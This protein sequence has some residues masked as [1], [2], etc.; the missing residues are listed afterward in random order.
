MSFLNIA[1]RGA[2]GHEPENTLAA[3]EKAVTLGADMIEWD[4]HRCKSG[5]PV[6]IHDSTLKRTTNGRG[7]I[8][9]KTLA[10]LK[11]LDAGRGQTIPTLREALDCIRRRTMVNIELKG[12]DTAKPV[13][14]VIDEY[15]RQHRWYYAD[16]LISSFSADTLHAFKTLQPNVHIGLLTN[17]AQKQ[18]PHLADELDIYSIHPNYRRML[19]EFIAG[20]HDNGRK[21][22]P[23]TVNK[24]EDIRQLL[25]MGVDG[26][27]TDYPDQI[28]QV[29]D[30]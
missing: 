15:V 2:S 4:V 16:F 23:Y 12:P 6:I 7:R 17:D 11:S 25:R 20:A 3:F 9:Q 24:L 5:E 27:I 19:D 13:A 29:M 18:P 22:F 26:I 10:E 28:Y 14:D 1:H 21:V 8:A 30:S